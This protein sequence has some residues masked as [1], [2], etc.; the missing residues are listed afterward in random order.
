MMSKLYGILLSR[1]GW[2]SFTTTLEH[3]TILPITFFWMVKSNRCLYLVRIVW[4]E[5]NGIFPKRF[6][7]FSITP[8]FYRFRGNDFALF[9][10]V[11]LF[12]KPARK[13]LLCVV[14]AQHDLHF[15]ILSPT[16]LSFSKPIFIWILVLDPSHRRF[17]LYK[18]S[19]VFVFFKLSPFGRWANKLMMQQ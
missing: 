15:A 18:F 6:Q 11:F 14:F 19:I 5:E 3:L 16:W 1:R 7:S 2:Q 17:S 4:F 10:S 13:F 9:I 8:C 12:S